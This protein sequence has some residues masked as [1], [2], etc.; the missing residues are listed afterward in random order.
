MEPPKSRWTSVALSLLCAYF[1]SRNNETVFR[2]KNMQRESVC[3][4]AELMLGMGSGPING[5]RLWTWLP[6]M[7]EEKHLSAVMEYTLSLVLRPIDN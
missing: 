6:L 3:Q 4:L 7:L 1:K 5:P 2:E